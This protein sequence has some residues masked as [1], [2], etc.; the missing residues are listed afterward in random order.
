MTWAVSN[1]VAP[2]TQDYA[3]CLPDFANNACRAGSFCL[4]QGLFAF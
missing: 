4:A 3:T 2:K 1:V